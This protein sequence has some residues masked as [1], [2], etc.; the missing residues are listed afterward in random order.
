MSFI[1]VVVIVFMACVILVI[2]DLFKSGLDNSVVPLDEPDLVVPE[3]GLRVFRD[4]NTFRISGY[5]PQQGSIRSAIYRVFFGSSDDTEVTKP[6]NVTSNP[7]AATQA[8]RSVSTNL[9]PSSFNS[10]A[11]EH[12]VVLTTQ[13]T[14]GPS[15]EK[16]ISDGQTSINKAP[17]SRPISANCTINLISSPVQGGTVI[18]GGTPA[19]GSLHLIQ[20]RFNPGYEFVNWSEGSTLVSSSPIHL[21]RVLSNTTFTG[22]FRRST[23]SQ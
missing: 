23:D 16:T 20:A 14:N 2:F 7:I 8:P 21:F 6:T 12:P 1:K 3:E 11:G 5:Y 13:S 9:D 17:A 19:V 22:N 10:K 4:T 15:H 18:G